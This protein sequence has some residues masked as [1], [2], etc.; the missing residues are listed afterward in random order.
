MAG[1]LDELEAALANLDAIG[2]LRC[3]TRSIRKSPRSRRSRHERPGGNPPD[4]LTVK[5]A[6]GRCGFSKSAIRKAIRE[7]RIPHK[8][9]GGQIFVDPETLPRKCK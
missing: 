6:A 5:A 4:R 8:R 3:C 1:R 7:K 9:I 2:P